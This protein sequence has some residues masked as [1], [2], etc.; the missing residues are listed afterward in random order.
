MFL[1][2]FSISTTINAQV[3]REKIVYEDDKVNTNSIE[4][5]SDSEDLTGTFFLNFGLGGNLGL[6]G[7]K[8]Y[9]QQGNLISTTNV[10]YGNGIDF[11]LGIGYNFNNYI[12]GEV[13]LNYQ[14]GIST[15]VGSNYADTVNGVFSNINQTDSYSANGFKINPQIVFSYPTV[16]VIPYLKFGPVI[17]FCKRIERNDYN[18]DNLGSFVYTFED[19]NSSGLGFS[20][21]FGIKKQLNNPNK[22]IFFE[23]NHI[24][25]TQSYEKGSMVSATFN[26]ND[27]LSSYDISDREYT[28]VSSLDANYKV[29]NPNLPSKRLMEYFNF[30]SWGLKIGLIYILN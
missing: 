9:S 29:T 20:S 14:F 11:Q 18:V 3:K 26:D 6:G 21:C 23:M 16:N 12:S 27:I 5:S 15:D 30:N 17:S 2:L 10:S 4:A 1:L 7:G 8:V 25:L 19:V 28:Y 13:N 22:Y 24:T